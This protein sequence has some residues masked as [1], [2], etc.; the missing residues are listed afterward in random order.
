VLLAAGREAK[1]RVIE[2]E[3][4]R[5]ND[6]VRKD[7]GNYSALHRSLDESIKR[8]EDDHQQSVNVPPDPPGWVEAVKADASA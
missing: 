4:D 1:E 3:F 6:T 8:I 7:L 5:I 2:R